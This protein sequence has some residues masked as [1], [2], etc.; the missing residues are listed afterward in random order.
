M[1]ELIAAP[2]RIL[3]QFSTWILLLTGLGDTA[4]VLLASLADVHVL[5]STQ[6]TIANAVLVFVSTAMKLVQQNIALTVGQKADMI[7]AVNNAPTKPPKTDQ[8]LQP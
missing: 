6:L 4:H 8:P 3:K 2:S 1:M 5:T 7:D